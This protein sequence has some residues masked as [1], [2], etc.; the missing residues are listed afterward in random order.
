MSGRLQHYMKVGGQY[1]PEGLFLA[2]PLAGELALLQGWGEHPEHYAAYTYQGVPLKGHPGLDLLAPPGAAVHAADQGRVVEIGL[3][4]G[5][6]ERYVKLEHR[7]GESFYAHLGGVA[8]ESGQAV[9]RGQKIA[10]VGPGGPAGGGGRRTCTSGCGW[11]RTT[12]S[13]GGAGSPT[14]CRTCMGGSWPCRS[15]TP[16][17]GRACRPCWPSGRG[18]AGRRGRLRGLPVVGWL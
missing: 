17:R 2:P 18:S 14:R 13:T 15:R 4:R 6:F 7:W 8:V 9:E 3:E 10:T 11:R 16:S 1:E 5:G 12:G